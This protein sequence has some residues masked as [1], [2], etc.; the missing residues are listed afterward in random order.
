MWCRKLCPS[1]RYYITM[2]WETLPWNLVRSDIM[3]YMPR[4]C[5][6]RQNVSHI[7]DDS[8][9]RFI[10]IAFPNFVWYPTRKEFIA[11]AKAVDAKCKIFAEQLC[12]G[13]EIDAPGQLA[14]CGSTGCLLT[15]ASIYYKQV[16]GDISVDE[17]LDYYFRTFNMEHP[18]S[19]QI[20]EY[21]TKLKWMHFCA[22][23]RS[24]MDSAK[25]TDAQ[26][27]CTS[28]SETEAATARLV[29]QAFI[30]Q[31]FQSDPSDNEIEIS[32]EQLDAQQLEEPNVAFNLDVTDDELDTS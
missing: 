23:I 20:I 31:L 10:G 17:F 9:G 24:E 30:R 6:R 3:N 1:S 7:T 12:P 32:D 14:H 26:F 29:D 22:D 5:T 28:Q 25:T 18:Q 4:Y 8:S 27:T 11:Y 21:W 15:E 13:C 2:Y 16:I 19:E